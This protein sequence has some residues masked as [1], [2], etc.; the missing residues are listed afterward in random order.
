MWSVCSGVNPRAVPSVGRLLDARPARGHQRVG[1]Q[2][3][4][5]PGSDADGGDVRSARTWLTTGGSVRAL[6]WSRRTQVF[7]ASP[8][9]WV[10][11]SVAGARRVARGG[12]S[13][14]AWKSSRISAGC[15]LWTLGRGCTKGQGQEGC[16]TRL[17]YRPHLAI[18]LG[19]R[20]SGAMI[21]TRNVT[22]P[23]SA[24]S[25]G[26]WSKRFARQRREVASHSSV[27]CDRA[28]TLDLHCPATFRAANASGAQARAAAAECGWTLVGVEDF[29]PLHTD[30]TS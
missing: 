26:T 17:G 12:L 6:R 10:S 25:A 27:H 16:F 21:R 2:A 30:A 22:I 19:G 1:D 11:P 3:V 15:L 7:A 28:I 23:G 8:R 13:E 9:P 24:R 18:T 29:C 14:L 5:P 20:H 4:A